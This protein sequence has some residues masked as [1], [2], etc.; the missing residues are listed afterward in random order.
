MMGG[1]TAK[2]SDVASVYIQV[3]ALRRIAHA[4]CIFLTALREI[5]KFSKNREIQSN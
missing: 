5:F 4:M 2:F 3:K 1:S